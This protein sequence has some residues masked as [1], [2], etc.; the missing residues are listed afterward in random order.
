[1]YFIITKAQMNS[2]KA[3]NVVTTSYVA[4]VII[5]K[6]CYQVSKYLNIVLPKICANHYQIYHSEKWPDQNF[7]QNYHTSFWA[8]WIL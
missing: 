2:L 5:Y 1:M 3:L 4:Q 8:N 6:S 7:P